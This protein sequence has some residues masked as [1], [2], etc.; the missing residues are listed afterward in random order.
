MPWGAIVSFVI[1]IIGRIIEKSDELKELEKEWL[2]FTRALN[3]KYPV[4]FSEREKFALKKLE[5]IERQR[6]SKMQNL[7]EQK[8]NLNLKMQELYAENLFLKDKKL[9]EDALQSREF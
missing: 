1:K 6:E 5:E 7:K 2:I 3:K 4:Q 9:K 8:K